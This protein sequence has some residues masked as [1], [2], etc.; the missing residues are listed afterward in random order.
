[1][2]PAV[3]DRGVER[4][5]EGRDGADVNLAIHR[6]AR[7]SAQPGVLDRERARWA[8]CHG[9]TPMMSHSMRC[10]FSR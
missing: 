7:R 2:L 9:A 10:S 5:S 1:M 8:A 3:A 6:D 4:L